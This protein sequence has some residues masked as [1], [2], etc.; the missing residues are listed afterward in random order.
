MYQLCI[1]ENHTAVLLKEW[2]STLGHFETNK[3][4][5]TIASR[6]LWPK[7]LQDVKKMSRK[8]VAYVRSRK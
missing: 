7:I 8:I 2:H 1:P 5:S 6:Y 3:L 4:I